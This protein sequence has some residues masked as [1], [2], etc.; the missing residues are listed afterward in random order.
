MG[1]L[2]QSESQNSSNYD[3]F[4]YQKK[5]SNRTIGGDSNQQLSQNVYQYLTQI[6]NQLLKQQKEDYKI[7]KKEV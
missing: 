6:R 7:M 2:I 1:C 3:D 4:N 5:K